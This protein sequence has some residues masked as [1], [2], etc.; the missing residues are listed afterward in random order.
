[1]KKLFILIPLILPL[2]FSDLFAQF[3]STNVS[4]ETRFSVFATLGTRPFRLSSSDIY[5]S[6]VDESP[7]RDF[8]VADVNLKPSLYSAS[9]KIGGQYQF[10]NKFFVK[11]LLDFHMGQTNGVSL[12]F[13]GGASLGK[14]RVHFRPQLMFSYGTSGIML[15]DLYQNDLFIEVNGTRFYS[16]SVAVKLKSKHFVF[17]PQIELAY[18]A[19]DQVEILAGVGYNL[20]LKK[21]TPFLQFSGEDR[22]NERTFE[23]ESI[24]VD[25]VSLFQEGEQLRSHLVGLNYVFFQFGVAYRLQ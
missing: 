9:L 24:F 20:A 17:S 10:Q 18:D 1:M 19:T 11:S 25:N 13:G 2:I 7:S 12:D 16:N 15:G 6:Y 3:E 23:T 4:D 21:G 22:E 5:F 14:Q 8:M